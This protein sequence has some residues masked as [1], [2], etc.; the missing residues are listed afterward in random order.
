MSKLH[1][2]LIMVDIAFT[3][4]LSSLTCRIFTLE[5]HNEIIHVEQKS[6]AK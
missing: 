5:I 3:V 4:I 6:S 2:R 1:N